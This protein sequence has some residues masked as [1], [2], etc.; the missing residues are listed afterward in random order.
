MHYHTH[1]IHH[2]IHVSHTTYRTIHKLY[3]PSHS[4]THI[5]YMYHTYLV[6]MH[7]IC[8]TQSCTTADRDPKL[9]LEQGAR[10]LG[11][12]TRLTHHGPGYS[13]SNWVTFCQLAGVKSKCWDSCKVQEGAHLPAAH[14]G[15]LALL[16]LS[17]CCPSPPL[18][19]TVST[20]CHIDLT[21]VTGQRESKQPGVGIKAGRK[22]NTDEKYQK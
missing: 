2:H 13:G 6:C 15:A 3:T 11:S 8:T 9:G 20:P 17:C 5:I 18:L 14:R 1:Y 12:G 19:H 22:I 21:R 4:T 16:P 10:A 7:I